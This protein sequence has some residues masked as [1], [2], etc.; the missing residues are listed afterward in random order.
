M[1]IRD[2]AKVGTIEVPVTE[3]AWSFISWDITQDDLSKNNCKNM[4]E[5]IKKV[6]YGEVDIWDLE[7]DWFDWETQDSEI[8]DVS[9]E[10]TVAFDSNGKDLAN[11]GA[12]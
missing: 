2:N 8:S 4:K 5:F 10:E 9:V 7:N 6:K 11:D 1:S 12:V 3:T